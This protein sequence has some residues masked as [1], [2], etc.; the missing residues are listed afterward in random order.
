MG[1]FPLIRLQALT[2][3]CG[4]SEYRL[5]CP[6][7]KGQ[8][9]ICIRRYDSSWTLKYLDL[10]S[11]LRVLNNCNLS[12]I[13]ETAAS[14]P[15]SFV[16]CFTKHSIASLRTLANFRFLTMVRMGIC[17]FQY[18]YREERIVYLAK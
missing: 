4:F 14:M 18:V 11:T 9:D 1:V 17:E 3:A 6:I 12:Q 7:S 13:P 10:G 5:V 2:Q 16:A 15:V 8:S